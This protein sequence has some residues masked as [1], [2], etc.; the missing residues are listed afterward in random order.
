MSYI[1]GTA[2]NASTGEALSGKSVK[3]WL[4]AAFTT[5][6]AKNTALPAGAF[7]LQTVSSGTAHGHEG[8]YR[9][10]GV[11]YG[12]YWVS[13]QDGAEIG[14]EAVNVGVTSGD[15]RPGNIEAAT[16]NVDLVN[17]GTGAFGPVT[18]STVNASSTVT[19][20]GFN[21][22]SGALARF[23]ATTSV[24]IVSGT[25]TTNIP[26][27]EVTIPSLPNNVTA[28]EV[29]VRIRSLVSTGSL[30]IA[31]A[32]HFTSGTNAVIQYA[33]SGVG[34]FNTSSGTVQASAKKIKYFVD[35]SVGQVDFI[36][37]MTGY[38]V[39]A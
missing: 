27:A 13:V 15:F 3:L 29:M 19:G 35:Y 20:A 9:F 6:P 17:A 21:V 30:N 25:V 24:T 26:T 10:S 12:D 22:A 2:L 5:A 8:S 1:S 28:V 36:L 37:W 18:A 14:W 16:V 11:A 39:T 38:W 4:G 23:V 33:P 7:L 32:R 34:F 31:G